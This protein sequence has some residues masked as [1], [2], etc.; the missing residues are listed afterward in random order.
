MT[1][2]LLICNADDFGM[3]RRVTD[4]I[5]F[6]HRNGVITSTTLMT[7][8]SAAEYA[9][10]LSKE[11]PSLA[12]GVHLTLTEGKP[13]LPPEKVPDLTDAHG[14]FLDRFDQPRNLWWGRR[15]LEQVASE[16]AAQVQRAFD[17]GIKPTHLDSHHHI[18]R[19]P[20]A[21]RA[22]AAVARRFKVAVARTERGY[23]WCGRKASPAERLECA[24]K[25]LRSFKGWA[26]HEVNHLVMRHLHGLRTPDRKLI[27]RLSIP[28][29]EDPR[30]QLLAAIGN[31]PRGVTEI[32]FHP[33]Y[34]DDPD[35]QDPP[36]YVGIRQR[37]FDLATDPEMLACV[38]NSGV[39]LAN[40]ADT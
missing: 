26:S 36:D 3:T 25:N 29:V 14:V 13:L 1:R 31:L 24:L 39:E 15:T 30:Q 5:I 8:M 19:M 4:A 18:Q 40:F 32:S 11:F 28:A 6:C 9:C 20:V 10:G 27:L 33:G 16:F 21:R 34:P 7:N 23:Y 12:V 38:K 37:D 35:L 2:R 17:L 22:M